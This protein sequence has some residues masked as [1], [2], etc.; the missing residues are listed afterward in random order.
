M[1]Q[2]VTMRNKSISQLTTKMLSPNQ[3][4]I[5][6]DNNCKWNHNLACLFRN[7]EVKPEEHPSSPVDARAGKT[8][9]HQPT[10][11]KKGNTV[12][13]CQLPALAQIGKYMGRIGQSLITG[14]TL[15][16]RLLKPSIKAQGH[17]TYLPDP[18][19]AFKALTPEMN[20]TNNRHWII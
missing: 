8:K 12:K 6:T 1:T 19:I 3:A 16:R 13:L 20:A 9:T 7:R 4:M 5:I 14:A 11:S 18:L 10:N 17:R 2:C 15:R